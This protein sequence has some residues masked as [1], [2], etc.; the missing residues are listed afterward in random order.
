M[1]IFF[2]LITSSF[3]SFIWFESLSLFLF[4]NL[5]LS[6]FLSLSISLLTQTLLNLPFFFFPLFTSNRTNRHTHTNIHSP[7]HIHWH[8]HNVR[9]HAHTYSVYF[10]SPFLLSSYLCLFVCL[11]SFFFFVL[12]FILS[13]IIYFSIFLS[14]FFLVCLHLCLPPPLSLSLSPPSLILRL[15]LPLSVNPISSYSNSL[16]VIV[17]SKIGLSLKTIFF[18]KLESIGI[19]IHFRYWF[20]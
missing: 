2:F 12:S 8:T 1:I 10:L 4:F 6:H 7:T 20:S 16:Q 3:S 9:T 18:L 5:P 15:L 11:F 13:L 14:F 19:F 17:T